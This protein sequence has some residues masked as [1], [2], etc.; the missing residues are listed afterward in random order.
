MNKNAIG[1]WEVVFY[2]IAV[3]FLPG[4]FPVTGDVAMTFAREVTHLPFLIGG[5]TLFFAIIY[6]VVIVGGGNAGLVAA[7]T[8]AENG[9]KTLLLESAPKLDRG[10]N[11]KHTRDIRYAH[12]DDRFT[13]GVYPKNELLNDLRKVSKD[14]DEKIA[15]SV[16][17]D[18]ESVPYWME[19]HGIKFKK[20]IRGTLSLSRT[21]AFFLGGGKALVNTYYR[22]AERLG[23]KILYNAQVFDF[24]IKDN[25]CKSIQFTLDGQAQEVYSDSVIIA[26]GG[27]EANLEKLKQ[28]WG[29]AANNF[30]IRGTKYN[31]GIPFQ[32][33]VDKGAKVAGD[34]KGGHMI[35]V[36]ARAPKFDGGIVTRIDAIPIGIVLN[37]KGIRFYDEGEDIWPKRYA[38]W[39]HLIAEQPE[40]I[41]YVIVDS[42]ML[43]DFLPTAYPAYTSN[44]LRELFEILKLPIDVSINTI[45]VYNEKVVDCSF[46]I[47][48]LD[49]CHTSGLQ[50]P[51]SHWARR[52]D[53]GPFYAFPLRPGLT[54]TYLGLK[55]D[56]EGRVQTSDG[57]F[58]NV[59]AA[60]EVMSGNILTYGYLA[61]FGLTIGTVFGIRV[62]NVATGKRHYS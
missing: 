31:T 36:D 27:F 28:I 4:T 38:I 9:A 51:K 1:F 44:D 26:S 15:A 47:S 33:L 54:F 29:D 3:I 21:N 49:D 50:P 43:E 37:K 55:V 16:I 41:A 60:G 46:D 2:A 39:G 24:S 13:S 34:P 17:D 19:H 62:G 12:S 48:K 57:E 45:K 6:D 42:K 25:R 20:E 40:Q 8:S 5:V 23:V 7:I 32:S 53:K 14:F 52:I 56:Q 30:S 11:T 35:A 18:S 59:Y 22:E 58:E 10:G 61:G